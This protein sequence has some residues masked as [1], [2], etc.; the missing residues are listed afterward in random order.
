MPPKPKF[1]GLRF[2]ESEVQHLTPDLAALGQ[3][4]RCRRGEFQTFWK[5]GRI[6][7]EVAANV[8]RCWVITAE[9]SLAGY[10][11]LLTDKLTL[12]VP[13]L[14]NEGIKYRTVPAVKIGL[15]AADERAKGAGTRLVEWALEYAVAELVPRVGLRFMTVDAFCDAD[16]GYDASGFYAR[17]GFQF[18]SPDEIL[19]P[20]G[21]Y[22][23]MYF[24]LKTVVDIL[25]AD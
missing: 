11:T 16:T 2:A 15:L 14:L 4:F 10:L 17:L 24:Y 9:A 7:R 13:P 23:T 22:R 6:R 21:S 25:A 12:Q 19:P 18:V 1:A 20:V 5:Q 3:G 8:S